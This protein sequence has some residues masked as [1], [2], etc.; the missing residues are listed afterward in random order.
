MPAF[1]RFAL[2]TINCMIA[3]GWKVKFKANGSKWQWTFAKL[4]QSDPPAEHWIIGTHKDIQEAANDALK[5]WNSVTANTG[6][7]AA[8]E[9]RTGGRA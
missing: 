8:R 7:C 9:E 6:E 3:Q 4:R 1:K 2:Q 5:K